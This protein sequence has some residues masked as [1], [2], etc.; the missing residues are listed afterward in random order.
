MMVHWGLVFIGFVTLFHG[1]CRDLLQQIRW[2][3]MYVFTILGKGSGVNPGFKKVLEMN[4]II[5]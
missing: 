2:I 5:T 3:Q 4:R 1:N